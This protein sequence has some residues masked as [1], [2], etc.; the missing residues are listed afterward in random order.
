ME[1][2]RSDSN[3]RQRDGGQHEAGQ[4]DSSLL[5]ATTLSAP[6][7]DC[8]WSCYNFVH[9]CPLFGFLARS[10]VSSQAGFYDWTVG[11]KSFLWLGGNQIFLDK[12]V[13]K[14]R[15]LRIKHETELKNKKEQII[16]SS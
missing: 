1:P 10:A 14:M 9:C 5:G 13:I 11:M 3:R 16:E 15:D 12:Q 4:H 2:R 8:Q 7:T 6:L